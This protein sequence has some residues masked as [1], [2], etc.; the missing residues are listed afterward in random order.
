MPLR[1]FEL[2][3]CTKSDM[4]DAKNASVGQSQLMMIVVDLMYELH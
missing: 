3:Q 1:E 4:T 2:M